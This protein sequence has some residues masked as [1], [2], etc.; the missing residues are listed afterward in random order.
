VKC[1]RKTAV[2]RFW[3]PLGGLEAMYVVHLRLIGKRA[4]DF[5]L[6]LIELFFA[7]CYNW[8]A[9]SEYRLKIGV[10]ATT[11]SLNPKFQGECVS[12][13][14]H[15]SCQKTRMNDL[16]CGVRMWA[17]FL[18]FC[19]FTRLTDGRTDRRTAFSWLYRALHYTQ[20]HGKTVY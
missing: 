8:G 20:S 19:Q 13:I 16:S 1:R 18:S 11:W 6:V 10:F 17:K 2:L 3:A 14:N 7:T 15:S 12:P 5:L 9:T 4:V